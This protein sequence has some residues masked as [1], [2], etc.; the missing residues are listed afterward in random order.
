MKK[1]GESATR[2]RMASLCGS[3]ISKKANASEAHTHKECKGLICQINQ[4]AQKQLNLSWS[5]VQ[6]LVLSFILLYRVSLQDLFHL[7]AF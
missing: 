2:Q 1:N 4:I 6:Q 5:T 7:D 3:T